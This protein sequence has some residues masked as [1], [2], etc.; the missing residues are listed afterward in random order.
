[1]K[2]R[3]EPKMK[4]VDG[5]LIIPLST[6]ICHWLYCRVHKSKQPLF[7]LYLIFQEQEQLPH[8]TTTTTMSNNKTMPP[9]QSKSG[10]PTNIIQCTN[11]KE[12]ALKLFNLPGWLKRLR[13]LKS[14][15]QMRLAELQSLCLVHLLLALLCLLTMY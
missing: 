5:C 3:Q 2:N 4:W 12:M 10:I 14:L 8:Q 6:R 13:M 15:K 11:P 9:T 1:M 7:S